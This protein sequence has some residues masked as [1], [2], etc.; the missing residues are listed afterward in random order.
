MLADNIQSY[1]EKLESADLDSLRSQSRAQK[2]PS[3]SPNYF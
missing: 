1:P 2:L 3:G